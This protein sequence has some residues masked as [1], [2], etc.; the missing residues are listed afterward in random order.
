MRITLI[1]CRE[2]WLYCIVTIS[3]FFFLPSIDFFIHLNQILHDYFLGKS[4]PDS[5][6]IGPKLLNAVA[7][8]AHTGNINFAQ[9][10]INSPDIEMQEKLQIRKAPYLLVFSRENMVDRIPLNPNATESELVTS[11]GRLTWFYVP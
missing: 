6:K 11:L 4:K 8:I 3:E 1:L 9:F 5:Q 10:N 2:N 7:R